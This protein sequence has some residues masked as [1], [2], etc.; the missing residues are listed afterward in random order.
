MIRAKHFPLSN[1]VSST[2]LSF[3][4]ALFSLTVA[5]FNRDVG[6]GGKFVIRAEPG[7]ES[8]VLVLAGEPIDEPIA[9]Q[10][11]FVMNTRQEIMQA[12]IDFQSGKFGN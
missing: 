9:A 8:Q 7:Q 10:G 6:K 4:A 5:L 12:N 1:T 2:P 3:S 11:P